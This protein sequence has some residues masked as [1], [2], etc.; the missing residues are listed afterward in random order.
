MR[1]LIALALVL[2]AC[3]QA[4]RPVPAAAHG[5]PSAGTTRGPDLLV[6]RLPRGGGS[7]RVYAYP[8][9]D[10]VVWSATDPAPSIERVLSFDEDAGVVAFIDGK[11]APG[12]ID[13]RQDNVGPATKS[14]LS[15][16]TSID[17]STVYGLTRDGSL[18]RLTPS[19]DWSY[20]P[21]RAA[22]GVVP[23]TDGSVLV[24]AGSKG[25]SAVIWRLR[26]PEPKLLDTAQVAGASKAPWVQAGDRLYFNVGEELVGVR[27]R[28]LQAI[29]PIELDGHVRALVATPSGDRVYALADS[30]PRVDIVDRY[31][32]RVAG[33]IELPGV[34]QSVRIDPFGRYLLIRAATGDSVW[35]VAVGTDRLIGTVHSSWRADL[36][37]VAPDGAIA[38]ASAGDVIFVD[39]ET[40]R[41]KRRIEKGASDFWYSFSWTG[42]RPRAAS[43]DEPV[44]FPGADSAA[45]TDSTHRADSTPV[46][47]TTP[48]PP[49]RDSTPAAAP[50]VRGWI[51]S[52]AALLSESKARELA[53]L[54]NVR[55]EAARVLATPRD[56][57]VIYRVVL[58]PYPTKEEAER[59]GKES[60]QSYWVYE[61]TP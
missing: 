43:L 13:F 3:G 51:V 57:Q 50:V 41:E 2:A 33:H 4:D 23:Q 39:G 44:R 20:K 15:D 58:G 1:T 24:I 26:P 18:T 40:L 8:R 48:P 32:E 21:P 46:V 52:F 25:D 19:G 22:R 16:L 54:I 5:A 42:F 47:T 38:L 27:T 17:G 31:R 12:R 55:G 59:V 49:V 61:A 30:A 56:G 6:M 11:G 53:A 28:D 29:E 35:V 36:P 45:L 60:R 37:F 34:A 7:L 14:K 9:L 10:S